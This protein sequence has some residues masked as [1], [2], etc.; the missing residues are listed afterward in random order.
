MRASAPLSIAGIAVPSSDDEKLTVTRSQR[1]PC[2]GKGGHGRDTL[3]RGC[4]GP[5]GYRSAHVTKLEQVCSTYVKNRTSGSAADR[6]DFT[7][8]DANNVGV[9]FDT[10]GR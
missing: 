7:F 3:L 6:R 9:A 5:N 4:L 10:N 8:F 2:W 1:K